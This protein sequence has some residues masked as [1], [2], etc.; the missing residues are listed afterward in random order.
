M[1]SGDCGQLTSATGL[2]IQEHCCTID[3][4]CE[5]RHGFAL[6]R[7]TGVVIRRHGFAFIHKIGTLG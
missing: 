6:R 5:H 4:N 7:L 2:C 3:K 1:V